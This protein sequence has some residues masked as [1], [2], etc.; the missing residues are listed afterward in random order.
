MLTTRRI[1]ALSDGIFAFAMTLLVINL[2]LPDVTTVREFGLAQVLAGQAHKFLNY[3]V[4]FLVLAGFWSVN[5][6]QFHIIEKTDNVHLWINVA[7]LM[8]VA[9]VP[10]TTDVMGDW[11]GE[12]TAELLFG[13]NILVLGILS[14]ASWVYA[15]R[16]G[17][18]LGGEISLERVRIGTRR[19]MVGPVVAAVAM[20]VAFFAPGYS[21]WVYLAI[22]VTLALPWFRYKR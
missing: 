11:T 1:E 19:G 20:V 12:M 3:A 4:S 9:L 18:L 21:N 14:V 8:F 2:A 17:H 16:D 5:H 13:G 6:Q 7:N 22:P 10:F 15:S